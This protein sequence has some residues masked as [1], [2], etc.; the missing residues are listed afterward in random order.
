MENFRGLRKVIMI[1]TLE[2]KGT[3]ESMS[4]IV[5]WFFDLEQHGGS[6]GGLIGKIDPADHPENIAQMANLPQKETK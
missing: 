1:D 6:H 3:P 4:R 5:H 2:G